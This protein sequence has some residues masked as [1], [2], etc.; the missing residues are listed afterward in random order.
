ML[1]PKLTGLATKPRPP[2]KI[3]KMKS[4]GLD[5]TPNIKLRAPPKVVQKQLPEKA[6]VKMTTWLR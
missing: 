3:P 4:K 6:K 2:E 1:R 5:K